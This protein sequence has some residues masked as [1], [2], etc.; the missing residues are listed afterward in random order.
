M[1]FCPNALFIFTSFATDHFLTID[2]KLNI[3]F[4]EFVYYFWDLPV[5][6]CNHLVSVIDESFLPEEG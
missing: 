1:T 3:S 2:L 5:I 6:I 4:F